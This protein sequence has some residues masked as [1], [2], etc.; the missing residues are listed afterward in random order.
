MWCCVWEAG[1]GRKRRVQPGARSCR[2][3]LLERKRGGIGGGGGSW[4]G[5]DND[6]SCRLDLDAGRLSCGSRGHSGD[7]ARGL[8]RKEGPRRASV[9]GRA[10]AVSASTSQLQFSPRAPVHLELALDSVPRRRAAGARGLPGPHVP[11]Q[12]VHADQYGQGSAAFW[13][14]ASEF[15]LP[16]PLPLSPFPSLPAH[17]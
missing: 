3:D 5:S 17:I 11:L 7:N 14:A 1:P 6:N 8:E 16:L 12:R 9:G 4:S 15:P 10:V 13:H 2:E